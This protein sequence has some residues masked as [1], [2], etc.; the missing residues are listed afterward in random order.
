MT[1]VQV[2]DIIRYL[3]RVEG[4]DLDIIRAEILAV[5]AAAAACGAKVLRSDGNAYIIEHGVIVT[6][7]PDDRQRL[8]RREGRRGRR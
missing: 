3:E 6:V 4:L 2:S 8:P 7:R 5:A 1:H